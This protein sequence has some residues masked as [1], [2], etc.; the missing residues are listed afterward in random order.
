MVPVPP[1][2]LALDAVA[3]DFHAR[4]LAAYGHADAAGSVE[5]VN[6][7]IAAWGLVDKPAPET[8][9]GSAHTLAD[10]LVDRRPVWFDGRAVDGPV[11]E[12]ERLPAAA[13][14]PGPGVI[15]EFGA[16]TVVFPGWRARVE[17]AGDLVLERAR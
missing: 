14:V 11:Y 8:A 6:A 13:V 5:L 1:G 7:R 9:A 10:A 17:R 15:E 12:R 4:H 3:Q 16:T 2:P